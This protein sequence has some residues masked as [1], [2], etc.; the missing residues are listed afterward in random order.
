[1][2]DPVG[3][4]V[5]PGND[6][7]DAT[8]TWTRLDSTANLVARYEIRRGRTD[9]TEESSTGTARIDFNDTAGTLDPTYGSSLDLDGKPAA[10]ALHNPVTDSWATIFRG[11]IDDR[12]ATVDPS[13]VVT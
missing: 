3:V 5:A 13:Q 9:I 11:S 1:M 4:N 2:A 12:P 6:L 8:P 10:L 7:L